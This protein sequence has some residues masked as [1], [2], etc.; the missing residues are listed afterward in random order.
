MPGQITLSS[1]SV[2]M[3]LGVALV[4]ATLAGGIVWTIMSSHDRPK[5]KPPTE[6]NPV[7]V[8]Q[9]IPNPAGTLA[10]N[11][12]SAQA[13][14]ATPLPSPPNPQSPLTTSV[15]S[16]AL[17]PSLG[18]PSPTIATASQ[19]ESQFLDIAKLAANIRPA[20]ALLSIYDDKGKLV[21]T[22][23]AFFTSRDGRLVTNWHV[24]EGAVWATAKLENGATYTI[25]GIYNSAPKWDLALLQ[26]EATDVPFLPVSRNPLPQVG[27]RIA[28]IGSPLGLEGTVSEGIISS[29]RALSK[30]DHWLQ[31]TA[32]VSPGSS[33]SPVVDRNGEVIGVA[34]FVM[35][36]SQ[37]LN[38][39]RPAEY[40]ARLVE[41]TSV[42]AEPKP[43][44]TR[45]SQP[46]N[47]ATADSD[48]AAVDKALA[49]NDAINAL[50]LLNTLALKHSEEAILWFKFGYAYDKLGLYE[51]AVTAYEKALNILPT[52]GIGLTNMGIS[53]SKLKRWKEAAKAGREAIKIVPDYPQAWALLGFVAFEENKFH[54]AV[55]AFERATQLKPDEA[56][57][58]RWLSI[59][60]SRVG[61]VPKMHEADTK[62]KTL[63]SATLPS[64][65]PTGEADRF[66]QLVTR[67]L[68][69]LE[70][71]DV[72]ASMEKYADHV[73]YY[74]HGV[75][76][77]TFITKDL[78][79]YHSRWPVLKIR[80]SSPVEVT[81]TVNADEKKLTFTYK[82][83][84]SSATR[85]RVSAGAAWNEWIVSTSGDNLNVISENQ[86]VTSRR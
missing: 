41:S 62:W 65:A 15:A 48:F 35:R 27:T 26:A 45:S 6:T 38:F 78:Q 34:T 10:A 53:L 51:D 69:A 72:A 8:S 7:S 84:A 60:Y 25:T 13:P 5:D 56:E 82:F 63:R 81:D 37:A 68:T 40:V 24:I 83:E 67:S 61:N 36:E 85:N 47:P 21:K 32:P 55:S 52:D 4:S 44:W 22:G 1:K 28:V 76:D 23:T 50:K 57:N 80:L 18:S 16:P 3:L 77:R 17:I 2:T 19:S 39:A 66:T 59:C 29:Q 75:V 14:T 71:N 73:N 64:N 74:D 86:K 70:Q 31:M 42:D 12:P 30:K 11:A 20:V 43:L 79:E 9:Q 49:E 46:Q 58:W 54:D 33:G